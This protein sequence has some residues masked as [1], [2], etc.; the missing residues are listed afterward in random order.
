MSQANNLRV[1]LSISLFFPFHIQLTS[2]FCQIYPHLYIRSKDSSPPPTLHTGPGHVI[3]L[4]AFCCHSLTAT[5]THLSPQCNQPPP[6]APAQPILHVDTEMFF[7][8]Q[9]KSSDCLEC[10]RM[11]YIMS[12]VCFRITWRK[13]TYKHTGGGST[14][15]TPAVHPRARRSHTALS[16]SFRWKGRS[17]PSGPSCVGSLLPGCSSSDLHTAHSLS[18]SRPQ[19]KCCLFGPSWL[20]YLLWLS[21]ILVTT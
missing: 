13:R 5:V 16:L 1:I 7:R 19:L 3:S 18:L 21:A 20:P 2:K 10:S 11:K 14:I 12:G 17:F 8:R 4:Q 9:R 6:P 15:L